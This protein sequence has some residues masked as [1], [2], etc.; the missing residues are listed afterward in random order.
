MPLYAVA[1]QIPLTGSKVAKPVLAHQCT[2]QAP[3]RVSFPNAGVEELNQTPLKTF[4]IIWS[5]DCTWDILIQH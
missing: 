3:R 5:T 2:K 4:G 1:L